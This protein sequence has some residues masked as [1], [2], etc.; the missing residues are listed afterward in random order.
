MI[1]GGAMVYTLLKAQGKP[2]GRSLVEDA[3]IPEANLFLEEVKSLNKTLYLPEDH[4]VVTDFNDVSSALVKSDFS[5]GDI[6]VD[7]GPK[8]I[9]KIQSIIETSK[10]VFWNGPVGV[11]ETPDYAKGTFD[12]AKSLANANHATTI[13]GGGD[14]IA[15]VNLS[16]HADK[17]DHISTGGGAS[18]GILRRQSLAWYCGAV[19][20]DDLEK[21]I[22]NKKAAV[23][24][25]PF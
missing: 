15:A 12:I 22:L 17:I 3:L 23:V 2:V 6:G 16:G 21:K 10:T 9:G 25:M 18:L 19:M 13:V 24:R 1:L 5:D 11:F 14:S 7:I 20:N 4:L 8:S